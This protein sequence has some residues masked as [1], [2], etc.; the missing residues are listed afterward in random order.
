MISNINE[1]DTEGGEQDEEVEDG[2]DNRIEVTDD[3]IVQ[4]SEEENNSDRSTSFSEDE[5]VNVHEP[6]NLADVRKRVLRQAFLTAN[7]SH[8][9]GNILLKTLREFP[10]NLNHLPKDT[11]TLLQTP[12]VVANRYVQQLAGVQTVPKYIE[13]A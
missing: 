6:E 13:M 9:Q 1:E 12:T 8:K 3:D 2:R 5:D 7:L 11:R 4:D 10:F